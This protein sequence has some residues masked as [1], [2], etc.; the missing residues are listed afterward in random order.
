MIWLLLVIPLIFSAIVVCKRQRHSLWAP[1]A[2]L[3]VSA[4]IIGIFQGA[5]E[6]AN[7][8]DT[9]YWGN[10]LARAEYYEAWDERVSCRHPKYRTETYSCGTSDSPRTCTRQVQDGY[11]HLYDVDSHPPEW[12]LIDSSG[13][14]LPTTESRFESL[15]QK[16][17]N[18]NFV[19]LNRDYHSRDGDKYET[20]WD[21]R[22]ETLVP[23]VTEH[24]YINRVPASDSVFK[25]PDITPE[26][27]KKRGLFEYPR[28]SSDYYALSV[29]GGEGLPGFQAAL[30]QLDVVNARLGP[31]KQVRIWVLV[32]L[33]KSLQAAVDQQSYWQ[34][35]NKNE[36]VLCIGVNKKQEVQ[37]CYPFSWTEVEALKVGVRSEVMKQRGRV[38]DLRPVATWLG[39]NIEKQ[40]IRKPFADFEYLTIP[41]PMWAI[42]TAFFLVLLANALF[43]TYALNDWE[44]NAERRR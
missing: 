3:V 34:G 36:F 24:S 6:W 17:K 9:E 1:I 22:D 23:L 43:W 44:S 31:K 40:W 39:S 10:T 19:E 15:A 12:R 28:V 5:G 8:R 20:T 29:L 4:L 25:F 37:W 33:D 27:A 13:A 26:Q 2:S 35:G 41:T 16:F 38:L 7:T 14:E 21:E 42:V 30:Q 11:Q 32:F 18:R